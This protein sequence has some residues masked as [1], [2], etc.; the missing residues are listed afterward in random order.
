MRNE[1]IIADVNKGKG[2][3]L[4]QIGS[5]NLGGV[6][7][8]KNL[9]REARLILLDKMKKAIDNRV[10]S[11]EITTFENTEIRT[12]IYPILTPV[13]H[14]AVGVVAIY[15]YLEEEMPTR[16]EIGAI[17]WVIDKGELAA[18]WDFTAASIYGRTQEFES[19]AVGGA[20]KVKPNEWLTKQIN[21]QYQN[22]LQKLIEEAAREDYEGHGILSYSIID[23]ETSEEKFL[24]L[25]AVNQYKTADNVSFL[26]MIREIP[27][28]SETMTV[29]DHMEEPQLRLDALF[30]LTADI[31]LAQINCETGR[32]VQVLPGWNLAG[33]ADTASAT[34][35]EMFDS[36]DHARVRQ[37]IQASENDH[38]LQVV[39][40]VSI[41][42][43]SSGVLPVSLWIKAL[44][45][46]YAMVRVV[47]EVAV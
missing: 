22:T 25:S 39:E 5:N 38:L 37:G 34:F 29:P 6:S 19:A 12:V 30:E 17:E 26:G 10:C 31:P 13:S 15:A 21:P 43:S 20:L 41:R 35:F 46:G 3:S 7:L 4:L 11:T 24:E 44:G 32:F 9:S 1:W 18:F 2:L 45:D 14:T 36:V 47:E 8:R 40:N 42:L 28:V 16:P 33:L 23:A 27:E